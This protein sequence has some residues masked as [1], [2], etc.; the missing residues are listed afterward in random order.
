MSDAPPVTFVELTTLGVHAKE[1]YDVWRGW[2][3]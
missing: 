2:H 1:Q 3:K